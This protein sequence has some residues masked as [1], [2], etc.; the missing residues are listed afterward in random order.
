MGQACVNHP[1][2]KVEGGSSTQEERRGRQRRMTLYVGKCESPCYARLT[3][4]AFFSRLAH[5]PAGS[6]Q[7][8]PCHESPAAPEK[9]RPQWKMH[10]Q[11]L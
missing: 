10:E 7:Y 11:L 2:N 3:C 6:I 4:D 5:A 1:C 8:R 9:A